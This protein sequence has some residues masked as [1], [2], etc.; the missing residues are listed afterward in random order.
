MGSKQQRTF[1]TESILALALSTRHLLRPT[2]QLECLT[3]AQLL[4][5]SLLLPASAE[6]P[7]QVLDKDKMGYTLL[8]L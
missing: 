4:V 8:L 5:R 2:P 6:M 1:N 3:S 7:R